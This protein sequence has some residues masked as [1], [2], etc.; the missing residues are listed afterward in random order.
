[1]A[2]LVDETDMDTDDFTQLNEKFIKARRD[3]ETLLESSMSHPPQPTYGRPAFTYGGPPPQQAPQYGAGGGWQG[4]PPDQRIY[5]PPPAEQQGQYPQQNNGPAPF[6]FIPPSQQQNQAPA[7]TPSNPNVSSDDLYAGPPRTNTNAGRPHS[8]AFD[9]R[10]G[11]TPGAVG[12]GIP[13]ELATG[14]FDSPI[15]NRQ[16]FMGQPSQPPQGAPAPVQH[17]PGSSEYDYAGRPESP[18]TQPQP[19]QAFQKPVIQ[20]QPS[21]PYSHPQQPTAHS[22]LPSQQQRLP[23]HPSA[24]PPSVPQNTGS[25]VYPPFGA[26]YQAYQPGA[27]AAAAATAQGAGKWPPGPAAVGAGGAREPEGSGESFYR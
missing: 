10:M 5:S 22:T 3:Y 15:D 6:Y 2:R 13:H 7:R 27:G 24:P 26:A 4:Q 18:Y 21:D 16:S 23:M 9:P 19:Q 17:H 1:M 12:A 8:M 20:Q 14:S 11:N 25:P